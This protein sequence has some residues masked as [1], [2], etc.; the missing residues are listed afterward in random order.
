VHKVPAARKSISSMYKLDVDHS[1]IDSETASVK[2]NSLLPLKQ[3]NSMMNAKEAYASVK[4]L[5]LPNIRQLYRKNIEQTV[6]QII[7]N[8]YKQIGS[9]FK[10]GN[11]D[12]FGDPYAPLK[13]VKDLPGPGY[14]N[15]K[16]GF[17]QK[18]R[19]QS[20]LDLDQHQFVVVGQQASRNHH[21]ES[22]LS[23]RPLLSYS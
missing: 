3:R 23:I 11:T 7:M 6:P 16:S 5:R 14:Y 9:S 18:V 19:S 12:R 4:P 17:G 21:N 22:V 1:L 13:P 20:V 15:V 2:R 8:P 10:I